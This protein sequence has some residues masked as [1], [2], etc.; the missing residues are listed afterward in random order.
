MSEFKGVEKESRN[1]LPNS[2]T[3]NKRYI[4]CN[5]RECVRVLKGEETNG[6]FQLTADDQVFISSKLPELF[7]KESRRKKQEEKGKKKRLNN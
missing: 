3:E 6:K 2:Y 5:G 1:L 7:E 4:W